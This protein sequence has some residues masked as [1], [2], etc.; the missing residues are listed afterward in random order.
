MPPIESLVKG[1][2]KLLAIFGR[3][4]SFHDAEVMEIH[5]SRTPKG[6]GG[7]RDR[8]VELLAKIHAWDMTN[9]LDGRGYYV[10]KNHTLVTLRFSGVEELKLEGFNHQNVIFGLTIQPREDSESGSSKYHV[11]FDPSF[12]VDA[13]FDCSAIEVVDATPMAKAASDE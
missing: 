6:P 11:E 1:S 3:W 8:R 5:L 10:L 9:E 13:I 2:E 4:P 12:G 7:K